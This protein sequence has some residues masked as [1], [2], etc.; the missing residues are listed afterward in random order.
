MN[1][2]SSC[3]NNATH[4]DLLFSFFFLANNKEKGK[5]IITNIA[6]QQLVLFI[7]EFPMVGSSRAEMENLLKGNYKIR[8]GRRQ[9]YRKIG[10][11][12]INLKF[13]PKSIVSRCKNSLVGK[14]DALLDRGFEFCLEGF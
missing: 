10:K 3:P 2:S 7:T 4:N 12:N 6:A 9:L 1:S 11:T 13:S 8:R 5:R 14:F